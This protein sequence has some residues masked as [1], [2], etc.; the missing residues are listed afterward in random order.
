LAPLDLLGAGDQL[1]GGE[2]E[3]C[4]Q[5]SEARIARVALVALDVGDPTL[6]QIGGVVELFLG[7]AKLLMEGFDGFAEGDLEGRWPG[8]SGACPPRLPDTM[9]SQ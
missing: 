1:G 8:M 9:T 4:G 2:V 5:A 3:R 7:Q 6:V